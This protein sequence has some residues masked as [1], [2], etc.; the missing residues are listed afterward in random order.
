MDELQRRNQMRDA[1]VIIVSGMP[2]AW[3]M[4][5]LKLTNDMCFVFTGLLIGFVISIA[6]SQ[7]RVKGMPLGLA[8]ASQMEFICWNAIGCVVLAHSLGATVGQLLATSMAYG[9]SPVLALLAHSLVDWFIPIGLFWPAHSTYTT[10]D[11]D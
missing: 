4:M 6:V 10:R 8:V 11:D 2:L 5:A 7:Y 9:A 3:F 1:L